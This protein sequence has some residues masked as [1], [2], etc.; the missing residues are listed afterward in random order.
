MRVTSVFI[1]VLSACTFI[2]YL[3]VQ[4]RCG[5][6]L[7]FKFILYTSSC[8]QTGKTAVTI[9]TE[10]DSPQILEALQGNAENSEVMGARALF[11]ETIDHVMALCPAELLHDLHGIVMGCRDHLVF[12]RGFT[13]NAGVG[14]PNRRRNAE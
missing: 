1:S 12:F 8:V 6:C 9:A 4:F 14:Y 13:A 5:T 2:H 11:F 7:L 10:K 3:A